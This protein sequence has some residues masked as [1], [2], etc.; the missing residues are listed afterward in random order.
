MAGDRPWSVVYGCRYTP[1][2]QERNKEV[3]LKAL[4]KSL[5]RFMEREGAIEE[6]KKAA[7]G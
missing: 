2:E 5:Y 3:F 7:Q 6:L 4:A 1:E